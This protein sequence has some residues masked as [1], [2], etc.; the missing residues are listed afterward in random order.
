[1]EVIKNECISKLE[2]VRILQKAYTEGRIQAKDGC[3]SVLDDINA[4]DIR[5]GKWIHVKN[6]RD[7][8][9]DIYSQYKC[10]CCDFII[11][12]V[13]DKD[14]LTNFCGNCGADMRNPETIKG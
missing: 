5:H 2:V 13:Y 12:R 4:A 11:G 8:E 6:Y 10:S 1:M 7:C 9:G 14:D 3:T